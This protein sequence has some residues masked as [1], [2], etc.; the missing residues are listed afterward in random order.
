MHRITFGQLPPKNRCRFNLIG[1][2]MIDPEDEE[3]TRRE[4]IAVI[5]RT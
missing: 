2:E 1:V 5:E 4:V 3:G